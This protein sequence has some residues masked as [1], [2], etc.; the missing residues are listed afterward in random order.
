MASDKKNDGAEKLTVLYNLMVI[1]QSVA[2][3]PKLIQ[4]L[5]L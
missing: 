1:D 3:D 4:I 5:N 2:T